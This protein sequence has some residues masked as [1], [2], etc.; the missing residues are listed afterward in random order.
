[1]VEI[2]RN[3]TEKGT[4]L[5]THQFSTSLSNHFGPSQAR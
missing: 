4:A 1:M 2:T 5:T 3:Q